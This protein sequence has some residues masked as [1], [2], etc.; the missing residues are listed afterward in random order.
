MLEEMRAIEVSQGMAIRRE[1]RRHPIQNHT[2]SSLVQ[3][4]HKIHEILRRSVTTRRRE[5]PGGLIA[6]RTIERMFGHGQQFHMREAHARDVI[7]KL[8]R[9]F[10]VAQ[11]TI[12]RFGHAPPGAQMHFVNGDGRPGGIAADALLQPLAVAPIVFEIP[13]HRRRLRRHLRVKGKWISLVHRVVVPVGS[14]MIFIVRSWFHA[15]NE[16]APDAGLR[17]QIDRLSVLGPSV[18]VADD[19]HELRVRRPDGEVCARDTIEGYQVRSQLLISTGAR[20]FKK[21]MNIQIG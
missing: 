11:R 14:D 3:V 9:D 6:P 10:P 19:L 1:V 17:F 15:R 18:E 5:I 12:P 4:I 16:A 20:A 21:R 2:D 13:H 8:R 7:R